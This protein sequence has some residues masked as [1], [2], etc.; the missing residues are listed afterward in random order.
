MAIKRHHENGCPDKASKH[1]ACAC[2]WRLDYRPE[3]MSGARRR[4][5]FPTRKAAE[6]HLAEIAVKVSRREYVAPASI[7][8]FGAA[9]ADWLA[10]KAGSH[11]ATLSGHRGTLKHLE[12]I[13]QLRLDRIDVATIERLRNA[14]LSAERPLGPKRVRD[15]L[16]IATAIFKMAMRRGYVTTNPA[17]LAQ[18]PRN[19]V[20]EVRDAG[21]VETGALRADEVLSAD[22]IRRLLAHAEPGLWHTMFA[23]AAATGMRSEELG[24]L[25]WPD[26]EL[27]NSRLFVRRSLSWTADAGQVGIVKPRFFQPK[28]KSG[29]RTIPLPAELITMLKTWRLACP[30]S[31][32]DLVFCRADGEPLRR[33]YVLAAG[34]FPAC[35]RAGLRRSNIKTFRHS[36]A[37]G[38]LAMGAPITQVQHLLGHSNPGVTLR[39]YSHWLPSEDN[40]A[41]MRFAAGFLGGLAPGARVKP[42]A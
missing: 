28:T 13:N 21:E 22:E 27:D 23:T 37:S 4:V 39:V 32:H 20:A 38:L 8:T 6:R 40:G 33:S 34:L 31:P 3:G 24:A 35:R 41:A 36:F 9:A 42:A 10:E 18:R 16:M 7:P 29:Y 5:E 12:P 1:P 11:P 15:I 17:A 14:L 19:P 26:V 25:Q 30:P 2:A